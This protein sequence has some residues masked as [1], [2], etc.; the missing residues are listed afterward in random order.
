MSIRKQEHPFLQPVLPAQYK[1]NFL[2]QVVCELRFPTL[3]DLNSGTPNLEFANALR[4]SY[5]HHS[6]QVTETDI[7]GGSF[8]RIHTH[9]FKSK[10]LDWVVTLRPSAITIEA[11]RYTCFADLVER[12][13]FIV[14]V[15]V[16]V[17]DSDFFTR[18]GMRYINSVPMNM[19]GTNTDHFI[20]WIRNSLVST[21]LDED[22]GLVYEYT[23]RIGGHAEFGGYLLQHGVG[24]H[25]TSK[26]LEYLLDF[27]FSRDNVEIND[28]LSTLEEL[29]RNQ[30]S[31][32]LWSL[33]PKALEY[34]GPSILG[35]A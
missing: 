8:E 16:G 4:K 24:T 21:L 26:E 10:K 9:I 25:P 5:P 34:L 22:L 27:D 20:G 15:A 30:F 31:M 11:S 29:H 32:F 17:I 1:Q 12:V 6:H 28:T 3:F 2:R 7:N 18:I 35:D 23:G 13:K 33:G 14:N 19:T